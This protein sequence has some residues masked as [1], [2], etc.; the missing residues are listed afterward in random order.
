[1]RSVLLLLLLL[2]SL[3]AVLV[4]LSAAH[5]K[6]GSPESGRNTSVSLSSY[7]DYGLSRREENLA[8]EIC[9]N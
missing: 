5:G 4:G 7:D 9:Y 1:M 8:V 3:N 2:E 6:A